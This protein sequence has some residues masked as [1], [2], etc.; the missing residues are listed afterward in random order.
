MWK[1]EEGEKELTVSIYSPLG[2][3]RDIVVVTWYESNGDEVVAFE[4]GI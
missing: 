3:L 2:A 1:K 4:G